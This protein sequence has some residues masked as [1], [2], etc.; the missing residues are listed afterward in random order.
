[1]KRKQRLLQNCYFLP[2]YSHN[3]RFC[4]NNC[5]DPTRVSN[6]IDLSNSSE[7]KPPLFLD[8]LSCLPYSNFTFVVSKHLCEVYSK[9]FLIFLIVFQLHEN[10]EKKDGETDSIVYAD[11][12]KS[13]LG[14][15]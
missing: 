8:V 10:E 15:G 1:M 9:T 2:F 7:K 6:V 11:L 14:T 4:Q 3:L 12:D 5:V 13:A